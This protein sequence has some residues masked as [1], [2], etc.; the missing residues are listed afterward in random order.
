MRKFLTCLMV[1][2]LLAPNALR[3]DEKKRDSYQPVYQVKAD[4]MNDNTVKACWS[5]DEIVPDKLMINFESGE[6][7]QGDFNNEVSNYPWVITEN[8]YEGTYA[9]KSS[10][11]GK[12]NSTSVS[13]SLTTALWVSTAES[14]AKQNMTSVV[15]ISTAS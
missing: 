10:N 11:E 12:S 7:S 5:W 14:L 4:A 13:T 3:A 15:S 6:I 9:I 8:A 1:L 2:V